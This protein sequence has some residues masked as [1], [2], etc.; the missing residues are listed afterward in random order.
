[1]KLLAGIIWDYYVLIT[2]LSILFNRIY[3]DIQTLNN[4]YH[5]KDTTKCQFDY[6]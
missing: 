4:L 6:R 3:I 1:M 5:F 2:I